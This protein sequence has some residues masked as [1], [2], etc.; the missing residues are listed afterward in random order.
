L[1]V[2]ALAKPLAP[3]V[4]SATS[5]A[6]RHNHADQRRGGEVEIGIGSRVVNPVAGGDAGD[7]ETLLLMFAVVVALLGMACNCR[8]AARNE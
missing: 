1:L 4:F 2:P 5:S 6:E 8:R 3:L 7:G